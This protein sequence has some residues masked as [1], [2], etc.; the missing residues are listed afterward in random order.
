MPL[1]SRHVSVVGPMAGS[2][3]RAMMAGSPQARTA[4][5][6]DEVAVSDCPPTVLG[7]WAAAEPHASEPALTGTVTSTD[8]HPPSPPASRTAL[9]HAGSRV[10][11]WVLP[12]CMVLCSEEHNLRR[13]RS[14]TSGCG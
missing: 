12:R 13:A 10:P 9:R 7:Q 11:W 4:A 6:D 8:E 1:T 14:C 5:E 2:P 3:Q